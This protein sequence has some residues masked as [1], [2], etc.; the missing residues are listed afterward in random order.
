MG[1]F[2]Q[3]EPCPACGSS[4]G[5]ARYE[6]NSA[7]CFACK[8]YNEKGDGEPVEALTD[9]TLTRRGRPSKAT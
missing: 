4:D 1:Q 9:D 3:H 2:V 6:D 5:L 8:D 7:H